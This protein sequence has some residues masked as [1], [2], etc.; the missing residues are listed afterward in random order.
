MIK[1]IHLVSH[2]H[3]DR[4]WYLSFQQFRLKLVQLIDH[5]LEILDSDPE[6]NTQYKG[7]SH[8]HRSMVHQP[9]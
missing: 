1:T 5:L 6:F 7:W 3:W 9:G 8:S 2:T 4:E